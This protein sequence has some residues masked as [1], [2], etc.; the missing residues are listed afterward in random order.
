MVNRLYGIAPKRNPAVRWRQEEDKVLLA[1][2]MA[3][4]EMGA[5]IWALCDGQHVFEQI[6]TE[7]CQR[8]EVESEEVVRRDVSDFLLDLYSNNLILL[9]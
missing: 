4:N 9:K 2:S 6:I 7:I 8:Y 3:L 5:F 1:Q